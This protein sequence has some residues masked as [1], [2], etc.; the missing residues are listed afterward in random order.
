TRR[1]AASAWTPGSRCSSSSR[2][3]TSPSRSSTRRSSWRRGAT[4]CP[5]RPPSSRAWTRSDEPTWEGDGVDTFIQLVIDGL[6]LGSVYA[7][8][9]LA[10][11]LVNQSTGLINFS[12]GAMAVLSAYFAYV[13]IGW[14][15]PTLL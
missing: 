6:A 1:S 9:A 12:Q 11:V 3:R 14:G 8:L 2:T 7:A 10:I 13:L 4:C 5:A 15:L